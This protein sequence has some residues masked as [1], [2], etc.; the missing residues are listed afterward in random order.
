M[1]PS[2]QK[3]LS[4]AE[5]AKLEHAFASDPASDAYRPLAEAYLGMGRFMEA[6]VVCKKGVKAHPNVPYPRLLLARVYAEQGKDKK[7]LEEALAALQVAPADK[8]ALRTTGAL[9]LKTGEADVGKANLLKAFDL[10]PSDNDTLEAMK[11][12]RVEPPKKEAPPP[13]PAPVAAPP[14]PVPTNGASAHVPEAPMA[15]VQA[16][17]SQ[18]QAPRAAP[19]PVQQQQARPAQQAQRAPA[20]QQRRQQVS[21]TSESQEIAEVP[22]GQYRK[23]GGGAA[24]TVFVVLAVLVPITVGLYFGIGVW[25]ARRNREVNSML[26]QVVEQTRH[27]SYDGYQKASK[28]VE[29]A[30][31]RDPGRAEAHAYGALIDAIRSG[32]HGGGDEARKSAE[33]HINEIK[34]IKDPP[35][36]VFNRIA[37]EALLKFHGG[38]RAEAAKELQENL[39]DIDPDG[40]RASI[41]WMTLGQILTETG[42]LEGAR[43]ALER[44]QKI[45]STD[46]RVYAALGNLNHRRGNDGE[47]LRNF[48]TALK[49]ERAHPDSMIGTAS[50]ILDQENPG[51]AYCTA[52]KTVKALN[53]AQP[54]NSPK[55]E[56]MAAMLKSVLF[57]RFAFDLPLFT[58][59]AFKK[60]MEEKCKAADPQLGGSEKERKETARKAEEEAFSK[61]KSNPELLLLKGKKMLYVNDINGI[62]EIKKAIAADDTRAH[63]HVELGKALMRKEGG[64][65]EAEAALQTALSKVGNSPKILT[66]LGTAQFKQKKVDEAIATFEKAVAGNARNAE[67]RYS[68]GR[69]YRDEKKDLNKAL[70]NF[71]RA[72]KDYVGNSM[73][74]AQSYDEVAITQD[75]KGDKAKAREYFER[76]NNADRDY[77][78]AACH[79]ARWLNKGGD[80]S[81]DKEKDKEKVKDLAKRYME[82]NPRGECAG[83]LKPLADAK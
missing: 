2:P 51:L 23:Q 25:K 75:A 3:P 36:A 67:A 56:A 57:A 7:A 65:K 74:V 12:H 70:D 28:L 38:K 55:Q 9:Q 13:P 30:L 24:K 32:E 19:P 22:S 35:T 73:M 61:D 82:L 46:A 44:A 45:A 26:K 27:D 39:K 43:E 17:V 59:A 48:D 80:G 16:P 18:G 79:Y 29:E 20:P 76:A 1:P 81:K 4:P 53:D 6:M 69:L 62:D 15:Q 63:F 40:N 5:L 77:D 68:L 52:A 83:E 49:Y 31:N 64:D 21:Y 72:A 71:E 47:A 14:P 60:E 11:T 54:P 66:L 34:K 42:D 41:L 58:D 50:L 37:A 33:E 10:D 78:P 8:I